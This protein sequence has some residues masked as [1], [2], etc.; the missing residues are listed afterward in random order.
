MDNKGT[1]FWKILTAL[2]VLV[3]LAGLGTLIGFLAHD[4]A[5]THADLTQS[6]AETRAATANAD[7][8]Y[9]QLLA[10]GVKPNA[11]KPSDVLSEPGA[12][13]ARG[14]TGP[15]GASGVIGVPGQPGPPGQDGTNGTDGAQGPQGDPGPPGANGADGAPGATG[16]TGP[17]G[18]DGQPPTSW[19]Y[20]DALGVSHTCSRTDPFDANAPEYTCN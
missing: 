2:I 10:N 16:A 18:T 8:L 17:A 7:R 4:N 11:E 14:D 13:G 1:L 3:G 5:L 6:R 19:T 20:T 12:P 9:E 15:Q